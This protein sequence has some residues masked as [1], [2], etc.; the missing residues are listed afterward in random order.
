MRG[1][2]LFDERPAAT[3][4]G[5][6]ARLA[7]LA[8]DAYRAVLGLDGA[9]WVDPL[10]R[11]LVEARTAELDGC[12][13]RLAVHAREALELG[14]APHRL[15]ALAGWRASPLF[16]DRER[17]ALALAEAVAL[18]DRGALAAARDEAAEH[19]DEVELAQLLFACVA[20]G[21]WDRLELALG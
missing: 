10:L 16:D 9:L 19:F 11:E 7:E 21:V 6:G 8:P 13:E 15:A 4:A 17:A 5:A 3:G 20:A 2:S 12:A 1:A 14:E 18:A